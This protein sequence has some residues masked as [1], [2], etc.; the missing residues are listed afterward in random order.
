MAKNTSKALLAEAEAL[1]A[2]AVRP[3]GVR[4]IPV[5]PGVWAF[6]GV[7]VR[8]CADCLPNLAGAGWCGCVTVR[9]ERGEALPMTDHD[10]YDVRDGEERRDL[11]GDLAALW[12]MPAY[13]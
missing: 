6:G 5:E 4:P 12:D 9:T 8:L 11:R 1:I 3:L 2:E 7:V 10:E 13:A